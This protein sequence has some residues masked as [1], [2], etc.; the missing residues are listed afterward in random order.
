M[1]A[2]FIAAAGTSAAAEG[3]SDVVGTV[4]YLLSATSDRISLYEECTLGDACADGVRLAM[5]TDLAIVNGGDLTGNLP[6]GDLTRE[7]FDEAIRP[8]M[9]LA[10]ATVSVSQLKDILEAAVS[11]VKVTPDR[12]YDT[13]ASAHGA[14]PQISGFKMAYDPAEQPGQRVIWIKIGDVA[15]DLEDTTPRITLAATEHMLSGGYD[16]P[17]VSEAAATDLTL[18]SSMEQYIV[19]G[20]DDYTRFPKRITV[21]GLKMT[22]FDK[23]TI[24]LYVAIGCIIVALLY[25]FWRAYRRFTHKN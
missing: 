5:Q 25:P 24:L 11:H 12:V 8:D 23:T 9:P 7:F 15:Q 1:L 20:L 10:K 13:A 18:K 21:V 4:P 6:P 19:S 3:E 17:A 2:L 22:S 16:L 14:F